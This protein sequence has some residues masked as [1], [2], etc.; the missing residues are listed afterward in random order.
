MKILIKKCNLC[1]INKPI[2]DFYADP[3]HKDGRAS[4]CKKCVKQRHKE[5][6][7]TDIVTAR[8]KSRY[9]NRDKKEYNRSY[10]S[11]ER[12]RL[13]KQVMWHYSNGTM[14]CNKCGYN[15]IR[16]LCIDHIDGNGSL[17]RKLLSANNPKLKPRDGG[18]CTMYRW[19]RKNDYPKGYQVLC[20]NCN[21]I[22]E[23]EQRKERLIKK[24][25]NAS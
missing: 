2:S 20:F 3:P 21:Q 14:Q 16:A 22:K 9:Y 17:H 15:D 18:G 19:L 1:K 6:Y 5:K 10:A 13:K 12:A 7:Y 24:I 23:C 8:A 11:R 4:A 25:K